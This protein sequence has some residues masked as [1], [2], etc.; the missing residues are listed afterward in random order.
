MHALVVYES[1]FGNTQEVAESVAAGL[2]SHMDVDVVEVG[3]A[4]ETLGAHHRLLVTGAPTH[5]FGLS[6]P[7][8]RRSAGDEARKAA[9]AAEP[10]QA[11]ISTGIGLREWLAQIHPGGETVAAAAFDTRLAKPRLPGSAARAAR[12]R[13]RRRGFQ[14]VVPAESFWVTGTTGPLVDGESARARSWA[15]QIATETVAAQVA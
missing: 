1:M 15:E 11:L 8:T 6:R 7:S 5:A 13:L 14:I 12:R 4:P 9:P 2:A 3:D 10:P